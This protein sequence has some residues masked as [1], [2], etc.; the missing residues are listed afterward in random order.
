MGRT[1]SGSS[2][3]GS[4]HS[5]GLHSS[6]H[7]STSHSSSSRSSSS[8]RPSTSRTSSSSSSFRSTSHSSGPRPNGH[9]PSGPHPGGYHSG[10]YHSG[11]YHSGGYGRPAP[12]PPRHYDNGYGRRYGG[13]YSRPT[14]YRR[15][16][17]GGCGSI[18][19]L[20]IILAIIFGIIGILTLADGKLQ[21]NGG[22]FKNAFD[23]RITTYANDQYKE[24]FGDRQDALLIVITENDTSQAVYGNNAAKILDDYIED[25][26]SA[27]DKNYDNDLGKQL[28]GM[29]NDTLTIM[30]KDGV[31][32]IKSEQNFKDSCYRDDLNW[33]DTK[34]ELIEGCIEF[35]EQTGIQPYILLVK[36]RTVKKATSKSAGVIKTFII[37]IGVIVAL[38][39]ILIIA[40][41]MLFKKYGGKKE[42]VPNTP[43]GHSTS[44]SEHY[45]SN[46][47]DMNNQ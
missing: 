10:G 45:N 29:F 16:S 26:W 34:R 23:S 32:P 41:V 24:L 21:S 27:Y 31:K 40:I 7:H 9:H 20:V 39:I 30:K 1:S 35:H 5:G 42:D 22:L 47:N 36:E 13:G 44:T 37:V 38:I 19:A 18:I 8:S 28:H 33:V 2:H 11:G 4:S 14:S 46:I 6:T 25:M 12:P 43:T 17:G 15:S 3:S